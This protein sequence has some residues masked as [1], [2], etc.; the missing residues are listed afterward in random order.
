M[1]GVPEVWRY[2]DE[3]LTVN[4]LNATGDY[5][6]SNRSLAFPF[7]PLE[8]FRSFIHRDPNVDETTWIREFRKWVRTN[9]NK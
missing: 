7:L 9:L 5:E 3:Q 4:C 8:E 1:R 2:A 6:E